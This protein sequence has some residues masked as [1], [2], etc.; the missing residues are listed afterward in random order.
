VPQGQQAKLADR[1]F[2]HVLQKQNRRWRSRKTGSAVQTAVWYS[3]FV[4]SALTG[5]TYA[6]S[7]RAGGEAI[8]K[9][10][11]TTERTEDMEFKPSPRRRPGSIVPP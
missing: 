4:K 8:Q 6:G 3:L 5:A 11:L 2:C 10:F 9:E 1:R 7:L